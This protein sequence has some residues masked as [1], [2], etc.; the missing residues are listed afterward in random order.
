MKFHFLIL[1]LLTLVFSACSDNKSTNL[2]SVL[3]DRVW[4][5]SL[6]KSQYYFSSKDGREYLWMTFE[7]R[8]G[9][10]YTPFSEAKGN[11]VTNPLKKTNERYREGW[12]ASDD[13]FRIIGDTLVFQDEDDV[14]AENLSKFY[15]QLGADTTIGVFDY[16][17]LKVSNFAGTRI[18]R[19]K[20]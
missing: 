3:V 18:W 6:N 10:T 13:Y 5:S 9:A 1:V 4:I 14:N 12:S 8:D 15:I 20:K 16:K 2:D 7:R 17:T 19:T 11:P